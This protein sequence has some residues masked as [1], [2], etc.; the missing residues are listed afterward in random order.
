M[1]T[2]IWIFKHQGNG[3]ARACPVSGVRATGINGHLSPGNGRATGQSLKRCNYIFWGAIS[4]IL[5][6]FFLK[7]FTSFCTELVQKN[8]VFLVPQMFG[9]FALKFRPEL[10]TFRPL[11]NG[12]TLA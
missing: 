11:K 3:R 2:G 10:R 1:G 5:A 7:N 4:I 12:P 9:K 8:V 6:I